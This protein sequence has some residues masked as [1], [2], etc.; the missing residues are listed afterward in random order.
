MLGTSGVFDIQI[1]GKLDKSQEDVIR[2]RLQ[3]ILDESTVEEND[4]IH[5]EATFGSYTSIEG[6]ITVFISNQIWI[7]VLNAIL[8]QLHM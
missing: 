8:H 6:Y 5:I 4:N 1:P 2:Y 3:E 7:F